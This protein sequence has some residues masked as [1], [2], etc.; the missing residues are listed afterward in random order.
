M[1]NNF[2][3]GLIRWKQFFKQIFNSWYNKKTDKAENITTLTAVFEAE[4]ND[5]GVSGKLYESN[6]LMFDRKTESLWSQIEG[7]AVVGERIGEELKVYSSQV[8]QY[9]QFQEK[10]SEGKVLSKETGHL[11]D[12]GFYPY[13]NYGEDHEQFYFPV[14]INDERLPSKEIM[15][16]VN[17]EN[18]SVAFVDKKLTEEIVLVETPDGVVA[19]QVVDGEVV[20]KNLE[21]KILPGYV[22]MWFSWAN[23]N[24][25]NG[26]VW[27][28]E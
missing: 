4:G 15:Y 14:S 3:I 6:L 18:H 19:A 12:Y 26:I 16:I 27:T 7:R 21:G 11:R 22:A 25:E 13:G 20:A 2:C 24:Q 10:Y 17:T 8:M 9:S 5:F 1:I 23:H 28:G